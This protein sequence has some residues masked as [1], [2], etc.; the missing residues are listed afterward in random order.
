MKKQRGILERGGERSPRARFNTV[1]CAFTKSRLCPADPEAPRKGP[2]PGP[3]AL[4]SYLRSWRQPRA[5]WCVS[6]S[7]RRRRSFPTGPPRAPRVCAPTPAASRS[8]ARPPGAWRT[9]T[10]PP[11]APG[12]PEGAPGGR[13]CPR[14]LWRPGRSDTVHLEGKSR[15]CVRASIPL[16]HKRQGERFHGFRSKKRQT[17]TVICKEFQTAEGE[18]RDLLCGCLKFY[19]FVYRKR[20][21]CPW[22]AQV[23][24]RTRDHH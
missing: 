1:L 20:S 2:R 24:P 9:G 12:A 14:G 23:M 4:G 18:E 7:S 11:G 21:L 10:G 13:P 16:R 19:G 8:A 17:T 5:R 22:K 6:A 15:L 3:A